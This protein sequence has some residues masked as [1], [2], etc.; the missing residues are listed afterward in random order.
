MELKKARELALELI[1]KHCPGW[2]FEFNGGKRLL[3]Q[4]NYSS[5]T[6]LLSRYATEKLDEAEIIDTILHEIAHALC[7]FHNHDKVWKHTAQSI[8]CRG[9]R[10]ASVGTVVEP[11]YIGTCPNCKET[12]TAFRISKHRKS[13]CSRC[14]NK[15]N[16]GKFSEQFVFVW[17]KTGGE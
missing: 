7:R 15:Y 2:N 12:V 10:T 16:N 17:K 13:A 11:N 8:G 1:A 14:C 6:I 3:G 5:K 4:C 9:T